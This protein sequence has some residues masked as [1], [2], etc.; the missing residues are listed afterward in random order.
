[1]TARRR[2]GAFA[3]V[4]VAT[5]IVAFLAAPGARADT[6]GT[7]GQNL[8]GLNVD[9]EA[10]A[11]QFIPLV[12]GLVPAGNLSTGEF[13]QASIP[14][15]SAASQTGPASKG[16]AT[17]VY[18]G[19][20]AAALPGALQTEGAPAAFAAL[21][22][23][24]VLADSSYPAYQGQQAT[25]SYSP[26][27][28]SATGVGSASSSSSIGGSVSDAATSSIPL[29]GGKVTIASSTTHATTVIGASSVSS[30]AQ[31][32]ITH[33]SVLGLVDIASISSQVETTSDGTTGTETSSL[34]VGSVTVA[35]Q[36]AY[37]DPNGL[38]LASTSNSLGGG[39][40]VFNSVLTALQ[41]AGISITTLAPT[42]SVEGA[43]ASVQSGAVQIKFSD[44]NIPNPQG[45]VPVTLIGY[46]I[47]LGQTTADAQATLL[48][49]INAGPVTPTT[50]APATPS[51]PNVATISPP[52]PVTTQTSAAGGGVQTT[53]S[54]NS[55]SAAPASPAP[56]GTTNS[57]GGGGSGFQPQAAGFI[58][59]PTRLAWVVISVLLSIVA[60]GPLMGYANWQLLRG[61]K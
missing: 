2:L 34:Q 51:S 31:T 58:G 50:P 55:S 18:P 45:E 36:P 4:P 32:S 22:A 1:M 28:G 7:P 12:R 5:A 20:V 42:S 43:A 54:T 10:S 14:Y 19:P 44:T 49:S 39:I 17:P 15:S 24:P 16:I 53:T 37:I 46:E 26:P 48:P 35:G 47:D 11:L 6:G 30:E 21:F 3:L 23:D 38:H 9:S 33:V 8:A 25:A 60:C 40:A 59:M 52:A 29:D 13:F 61:R 56:R 27:A 41:Q 57:G